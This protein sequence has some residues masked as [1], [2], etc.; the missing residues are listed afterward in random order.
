MNVQELLWKY[1]EGRCSPKERAEVDRLVS[2]DAALQ[3]DLA[4]IREVQ[5]ALVVMEPEQPSMRFVQQV[6]EHLPKGHFAAEPLIKPFWMKT[7]W[8]ALAASMTAIFFFPATGNTDG[9]PVAHYAED[10]LSGVNAVLDAIPPM[11]LQYFV[12]V[13]LA[14]VILAVLDKTLSLRTHLN[15]F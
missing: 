1:A 7:F 4:A 3:Q 11:V 13:I 2:G 5:A 15:F 9:G 12:L 8:I 14:A 10:V 6:M